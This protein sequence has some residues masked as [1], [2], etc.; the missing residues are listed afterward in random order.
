MYGLKP[1]PFKVT[2]YRRD[3]NGECA[4]TINIRVKGPC[5]TAK[6]AILLR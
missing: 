6:P 2:R 1:V 5:G 3:S 4:Q